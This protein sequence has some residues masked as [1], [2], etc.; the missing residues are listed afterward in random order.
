VTRRA[1]V[2]SIGGLALASVLGYTQWPEDQGQAALADTTRH[3]PASPA[4]L[5]TDVLFV[6]PGLTEP[7]SKAIH[8]D[9]EL[10]GTLRAVHVRAGDPVRKGQLLAELHDEMQKAN[11][12]LA[13][14]SLDRAQAELQRLRNGDRPQ[15]V[16]AI[17]AQLDEAEAHLRFEKLEA[18]SVEQLYQQNAAS[19]QELLQ[20]RNDLALARARRDLAKSRWELSHA[21]AR[22]EDLAR[23]AAVVGEA[24]A[25]LAGARS[26]LQKTRIHS[27]IDGVVIYRYREPGEA[28]PAGDGAPILTVGDCDALHVRV[29]VDEADVGRVSVGQRVYATAA[30][31]GDQRILGEVVHIEPTLG[32]KNFRTQHPTERIDTRIQE[33]VVRLDQHTDLPLGLQMAVWFLNGPRESSA[34]SAGMR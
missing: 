1:W 26:V 15:E 11:V 33:V 29:D 13:Q 9:F 4:A 27:P 19:E 28:T 14:A 23:A 5:G 10:P 17:R 2:S 6:A 18:D 31:L 25:K 22:D 3:A 34:L 21:G 16:A 8:L 30:A 20:A 32:R 24:E 12:D 7:R